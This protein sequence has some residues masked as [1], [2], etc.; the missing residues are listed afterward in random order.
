MNIRNRNPVF[1]LMAAGCLA[2][3][4]SSPLWWLNI[5]ALWGSW[6]YFKISSET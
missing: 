3:A 2:L 4:I 5:I 6:E 1:L